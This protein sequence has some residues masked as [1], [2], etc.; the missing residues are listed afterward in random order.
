MPIGCDWYGVNQATM[1][2]MFSIGA[3]FSETLMGARSDLLDVFGGSATVAAQV[4][5]AVA[6]A[7]GVAAAVALNIN[8]CDSEFSTNALQLAAYDLGNH[9][10]Q[11]ALS[12]TEACCTW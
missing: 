7:P 12:A 3:Q 8:T 11:Q 2:S 9:T 10:G 1:E 4:A 5:G 6:A